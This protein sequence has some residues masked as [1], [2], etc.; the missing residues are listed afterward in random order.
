[1]NARLKSISAPLMLASVLLVA[2]CGSAPEQQTLFEQLGGMAKIE[3]VTD[4][5]LYQLASDEVVREHF[6]NTNLDRFRTM[7]SQFICQVADGPCDYK[8]DNM[9]DSHRNMGITHA[10]FNRVVEDYI[11]A[12]EK[13]AIPTAAQNELLRRLAKFYNDIMGA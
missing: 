13:N 2:G 1:M 5:F 7:M 6:A 4:D 8:G 11:V 12:M 3:A 10:E 9:V